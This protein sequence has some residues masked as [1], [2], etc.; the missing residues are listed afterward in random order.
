MDKLPYLRYIPLTIDADETE[1]SQ[2]NLDGLTLVGI[3][4]PTMV[5]T[6]VT[7]KVAM[8]FGGTDYVLQN[9]DGD[10]SLTVADGKCL[11]VDPVD[12]ATA[13]FLKI[14]SGSTETSAVT[15]YLATRP[16]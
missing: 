16:V 8:E 14:V 5:G 4:F 12:F 1:S 6:S 11:A 2:A 13:Q 9:S 7:F 15:I 3:F 10:V